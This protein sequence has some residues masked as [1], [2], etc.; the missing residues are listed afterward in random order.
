MD[1]QQ[2]FSDRPRAMVSS[3][4]VIAIGIVAASIGWSVW[5]L[6]DRPAAEEVEL[7]SGTRLPSSELAIIEAAFDRAQLTDY[8][9]EDGRVWVPRSRQSAFMRALV[10]AEALPREFGG[11]LRRALENNS[12]W[13]SK[14]VQAEMLRVATQEEL[15]LVI[16][17]MPGIERAAVLYD[18]DDQAG[19]GLQGV[20]E[21]TA[22]VSVR[23]QPDVELDPARVEAIRVLVASSIA[24]L[25]AD[26]VAVTDL[27][28]GRVH[29][30]PLEAERDL[31]AV[32]PELARR[33]AHE[34]HIAA[35]VRR[36]LAFVKGA[37][38]DVG[39]EF[40]PPIID[41]VAAA[42]AP[43]PPE[44]PADVQPVAAANAPAE[45][46]TD[47]A[48]PS[49]TASAPPAPVVPMTGEAAIVVRV[50]VAVPE[51]YL[52]GIAASDPVPADAVERERER[53]R[54]H[55]RALL[56]ASGSM[57]EH[58]VI[59]TSFPALADRQ[60][61]PAVAAIKEAPADAGRDTVRAERVSPDEWF[62]RAVDEIGR[63]FEGT[64]PITRQEWLAGMSVSVG[65]LAGWMWWAGSRRR[66][67]WHPTI[68]WS[69]VRR[70][71]SDRRS[72]ADREPLD[73]AAA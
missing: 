58:S 12:P 71:G 62:A 21:K 31:A 8:R 65:L 1:A 33:A 44:P 16:C 6:R 11:S 43:I 69:Q 24:G 5:L 4:Q 51:S 67:G 46:T 7:L 27:R 55:V 48:G 13:Q 20:R 17:S 9:S 14:S 50:A 36:A 30:G 40:V 54:G 64:T 41:R 42:S 56:P 23:T 39:V 45:V 57:V 37:T 38:I 32:D 2:F 61:T 18:V 59:V 60:E 28:N 26:R 19:G 63:R 49:T 15:A 70:D 52:R 3:S 53:I 25:A 47:Q 10:D 35:K 29:A 34:N 22:S 73:R 68:D 72:S 66:V